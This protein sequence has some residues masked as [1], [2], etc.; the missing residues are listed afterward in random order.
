MPALAPASRLI[1]VLTD[2]YDSSSCCPDLEAHAASRQLDTNELKLFERLAKLR[3]ANPNQSRADALKS[4]EWKD[5]CRYI[6]Q[7]L[8]G[9]AEAGY[10]ETLVKLELGSPDYVMLSKLTESLHWFSA[11][12]NWQL[13]VDLNAQLTVNGRLREW[14]D[15][16]K[17]ALK[18]NQQYSVVW[19]RTEYNAA[20]ASSQVAAK[21]VGIEQDAADVYVRFDTAGDRRVRPA[22]QL[23]DGITLPADDKFWSSYSPP[24][25]WGCRCSIT[26]ILRSK[27]KPTDLQ[28]KGPL[29]QI[30]KGFMSNVA[31][32]GQVFDESHPYFQD[33]PPADQ[34]TLRQIVQEVT[35]PPKQ[36]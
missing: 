35:P 11:N 8:V 22:H 1:D 26:S 25:D 4:K 9:G 30:A 18:L 12:K 2:L 3:H 20:V 31:K 21:W 13:V 14:A 27:T 24:L 23:L 17:E 36:K 19:L 32:S 34:K 15:F 5:L 6:S 7:E 33:V 16:K 29:P 10:G 28:Q